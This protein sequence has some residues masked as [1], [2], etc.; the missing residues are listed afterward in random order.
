MNLFILDFKFSPCS[1]SCTLSF[2]YF[3]GVILTPG[4]YPKESVHDSEHGENL[5]SRTLISLKYLETTVKI[6]VREYF[7]FICVFPKEETIFDPFVR[8]IGD[9]TLPDL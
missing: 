1:E 8:S 5:K 4:K 9:Y 3:P 6:T 2:G 7:P